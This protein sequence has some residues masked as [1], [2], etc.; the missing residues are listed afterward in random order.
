MS[1]T[2]KHELTSYRKRKWNELGLC[3][4]EQCKY[5][6]T[7]NN[8]LIKQARKRFRKSWKSGKDFVKGLYTD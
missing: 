7:K 8:K 3:F 2:I 4:C 5:G 6:R 1:K